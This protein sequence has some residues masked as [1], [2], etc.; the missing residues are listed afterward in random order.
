MISEVYDALREVGVSEKKRGVPP[1]RWQSKS[2]R[3]TSIETRLGSLDSRLTAVENRLSVV[4]GRL[5]AVESR[6]SAV[7]GRLT[8]MEARLN[9]MQ[10]QIGI[11]AALQIAAL[12]KLFFH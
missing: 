1:R 11:I 12:V 9:F 3:L 7:D 8:G 5:T 4:D 10:W 6:L 2:R